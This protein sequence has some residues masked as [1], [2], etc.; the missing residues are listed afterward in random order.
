MTELNSQHRPRPEPSGEIGLEQLTDLRRDGGEDLVC[1]SS[2]RNER[3]HPPERRLL[4]GRP[5]NGFVRLGLRDCRCDE[6]AIILESPRVERLVIA[7]A[8]CRCRERG[9]VSAAA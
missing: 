4:I 2:A 7:P 9:G 6:L 3:R 5:R 1:R 8:G